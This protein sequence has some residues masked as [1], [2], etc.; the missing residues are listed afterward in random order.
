MDFIAK[1]SA[2][3][4][5]SQDSAHIHLSLVSINLQQA[6]I[7]AFNDYIWEYQPS[8]ANEYNVKDCALSFVN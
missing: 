7:A 6:L 5:D 8:N 3:P 1:P 4:A 2:V